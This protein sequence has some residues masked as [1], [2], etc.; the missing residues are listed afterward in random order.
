MNKSTVFPAVVARVLLCL[1]STL[2]LWSCALSPQ[3]IVVKPDLKVATMPIGRGRPVSVITQDQR[4]D[5]SMGTRGGLYNSADLTTDA[6]MNQS[7]TQEA[8][9][10]LQGWDFAAVPR[11]LG[12]QSMASF[13]VEIIDIDYQ[14]PA[15][16][17]GGNVVVKC[18]LSVKVLM[19]NASY[20]GEYSSKRSEQVAVQATSSQNTRLVNETINQALEQMFRDPKLQRFMADY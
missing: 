6:R 17:V 7:I 18:R 13:S 1:C 16:S 12:N 11:A 5:P 9:R 19:G 20:E 15:S 14:R 3:T 10:V 2:F 8:I 4:S